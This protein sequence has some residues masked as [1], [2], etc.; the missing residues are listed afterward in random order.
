VTDIVADGETGLLVPE[1]DPAALAGAIE[2]LL[3][4]RGLAARLAAN[5][6]A[7]GGAR[8]TPDRVAAEFSQIYASIGL[9]H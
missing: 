7:R 4:D 5:G 3:K 6:R 8:F 9:V 2:R 1:R